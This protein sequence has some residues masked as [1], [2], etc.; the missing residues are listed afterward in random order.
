MRLGFLELVTTPFFAT[1]RGGRV[2]PKCVRG[3]ERAIFP[4]D[5][6]RSRCQ[7]R[8]L[9][10]YLQCL[11]KVSSIYELVLS[12][13]LRILLESDVFDC[14]V[15]LCEWS[16]GGKL[17]LNRLESCDCFSHADSFFPNLIAA[18]DMN[19][20]KRFS[21]KHQQLHRLQ[22]GVAFGDG[23]EYN[24]GEYNRMASAF[25]KDYKAR[26]YPE[27]EMLSRMGVEEDSSCE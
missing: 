16:G 5:L 23:E 19:I 2:V 21:T 27:H 26:N 17:G 11:R 4:C 10:I 12:A 3:Q 7:S 25:T 13:Q 1:T 8:T 20:R 9:P 24:P 18:A 15:A 6:T 14:I 22:E